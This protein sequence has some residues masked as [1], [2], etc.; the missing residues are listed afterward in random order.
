MPGS[1]S[2]IIPRT[3][4]EGFADRY[5]GF[6][7]LMRHRVHEILLVS[8]LYDSFILA[9]DG[10]INEMILSEF[11][12]LNLYHSPGLT[13][14]ANGSEAIDRLK[15]GPRFNLVI[16]SV[17]L[18]DMHVVE[19]LNKLK[20]GNWQVPVALLTFDE[21]ELQEL[22]RME[23]IRGLDNVFVWQ[24]DF[25]I[26]LAIVK[27]IEDR[28]NIEHDTNVM[29]VPVILLVE[30]NIHFYSSFIPMIYSEVMKHSQNL[31]S[32]SLNIAHRLLRMRARP[33]ILHCKTFEEAHEL[34]TRYEDHLLGVVTDVEF[35]HNGVKDPNAGQALV[36]MV[37]SRRPE[38]P[39][40]MQSFQKKNAKVAQSLGVSFLRKGSRRLLSELQKFMIQ[41][42]GFGDFIFRD[43]MDNEIARACNLEDLEKRLKTISVDSLVFHGERDHFST[44]LK[45]RTEFKLAQKLKPRKVSDYENPEDLRVDLVKSLRDFR[46]EQTRGV[47]LDFSPDKFDFSSDFVRIGNGSM[48]GKARGLAF[49]NR[50]IEVGNLREA[51][52]GIKISIPPTVVLCTDV[53]DKFLEDNDLQQFALE[54]D[55][56]ELLE[57]RFLKAKLPDNIVE[58]LRSLIKTANFPLAVRSSSIL[59][60]SQYQPFAGVYSTCML[61]NNHPDP[62]ARLADLVESII[63]IYLSTFTS[64]AKSYIEA[65]SFRLEEEKMAVI[66]QQVVGS[67]KGNRYYPCFSGVAKSYNFYPSENIEAD[68]GIVNVALGL[69]RTVAEGRASIRFCPKYPQHLMQFS[70]IEDFIE[71]SQKSFYALNLEASGHTELGKLRLESVPYGLDVAEKDGSLSAVGSTYSIDN[72]AIFDGLSRKGPRVVTFAPVLKYNLFPLPEI[73]T[74]ILEMCRKGMGRAVEIE[75]AVD[76]HTPRKNL[77]EFVLLQMRPIVLSHELE[78]IEFKSVDD[79]ELICRCDSV[80]G[81]GKLSD[82]KDIVLVDKNKFDRS[83]S[84]EVA[85]SIGKINVKLKAKDR[86]YL[87]I[88]I[89]RWGSADPWLGIPVKWT[90]INGAR[91]IVETGFKDIKV[92]PS[93]GA[94]FFNNLTSFRI[95]YFTVNPDEG[96]GFIDWNWLMKK[97]PKEKIGLVRHLSLRDPIVVKMNGHK[98]QGVIIKP[99]KEPVSLNNS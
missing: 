17:N 22:I 66:I 90:Q 85:E 33:K 39:V 79:E 76:Q 10:G 4:R 36:K 58:N 98:N 3:E 72:N 91:V 71:N 52:N 13:R 27:L 73:C 32:D 77:K 20:K 94:H 21:R 28:Q 75:Y 93:Q 40:I 56:D 70:S 60:D 30:D 63:R 38:L 34:Y 37:K 96:N 55:D 49:I 46:I 67:K 83:L 95:G 19:F 62:E 23:D 15:H 68:D 84:Q 42:F 5:T 7:S 12:E 97:K 53:F 78:D 9:Q 50:L 87:L 82:I 59:E 6:Q 47:V 80:M 86:P 2:E 18:G 41:N 88:G 24:G 16:S 1:L 54:T 57:E 99:G 29:G 69:G 92:V 61:G 8:S 14:V 81:M 45:A 74:T 31:L 51:F 44:W 65:T 64:H 35:L 48:G 43:N 11:V 89:G 25:R 26:L